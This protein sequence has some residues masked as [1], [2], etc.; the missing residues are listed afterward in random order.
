MLA[1]DNKH[2]AIDSKGR[3]YIAG[4]SYRVEMIVAD[5]VFHGFS[6]AEICHQHYGEI[7][8]AQVHA[9]LSYY[10]DHQAEIDQQ[11]KEASDRVD[12]LRL[13][14]GD[15]PGRKKLLAMGLLK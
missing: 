1:I 4:T 8:L 9:A 2:I 10:F 11:M 14:Q 5:H 7:T 12:A 13:A 3:P 15:S 6:A